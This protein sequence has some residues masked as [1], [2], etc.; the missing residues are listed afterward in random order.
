MKDFSVVFKIVRVEIQTY[1]HKYTYIS[2]TFHSTIPIKIFKNNLVKFFQSYIKLL[3]KGVKVLIVCTSE[4]HERKYSNL[5]ET[6]FALCKSMLPW[7]MFSFNTVLA[8]S[9]PL[10][11]LVSNH[12]DV[13]NVCA[14]YMATETQN[15]M[16][17]PS[18]SSFI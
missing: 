10:K 12:N 8:Y 7:Q 2:I 13:M 16:L 5:A 15:S 9:W 1:I 6:S 17:N 18:I 11:K 14:R 3:N 4:I